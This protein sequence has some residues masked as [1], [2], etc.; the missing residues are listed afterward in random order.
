MN[1]QEQTV[2]ATEITG[3]APPAMV[4]QFSVRDDANAPWEKSLQAT[5]WDDVERCYCRI[6]RMGNG[7]RSNIRL[8]RG[9]VELNL[10]FLATAYDAAADRPWW[11]N[12]G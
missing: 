2:A 4:Y 1:S 11:D 3:P 6:M 7:R 12:N 8:M 10:P 9:G 5:S